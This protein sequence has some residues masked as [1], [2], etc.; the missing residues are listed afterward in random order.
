[1][2]GLSI[3]PL[4]LPWP[5][6][7]GVLALLAVPAMAAALGRG[8]SWRLRNWGWPAVLAVMAM[9]PA[10]GVAAVRALMR[11][12]EPAATPPST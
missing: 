11:A 9:G 10:A 12:P 8:R 7:F 4:F 1:M 5:R 2:D 6:L 3:G